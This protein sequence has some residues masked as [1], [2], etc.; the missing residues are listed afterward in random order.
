MRFH[1]LEVDYEL[2]I[3]ERPHF[4]LAE[5]KLCESPVGCFAF[6]YTGSLSLS[7]ITTIR[8]ICR[9]T[10]AFTSTPFLDGTSVAQSRIL[11]QMQEH[12]IDFITYSTQHF[13]ASRDGGSVLNQIP[14]SFFI[15][16]QDGVNIAPLLDIWKSFQCIVLLEEH[17]HLLV[18]VVG[19]PKKSSMA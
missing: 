5:S 12:A 8:W 6:V 3:V 4:G 9:A 13:D 7:T 19:Q 18:F 2:H 14:S 16:S 1:E 17:G 11:Q 10:V 15:Q